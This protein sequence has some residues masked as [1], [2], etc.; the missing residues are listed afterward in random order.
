[1][2]EDA[3]MSPKGGE[4]MCLHTEKLPATSAPYS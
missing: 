1:M 4:W 3:E 2:R